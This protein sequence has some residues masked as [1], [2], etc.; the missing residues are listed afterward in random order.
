MR[1]GTH[2]HATIGRMIVEDFRHEAVLDR[3]LR[4]ERRIESSLYR[5]L[6][7]MR[8]VFDQRKKAAEE[9]VKILERWREED[10]E[11]KKARAF[12]RC[13]APAV[14]PGPA[15]G[16]TNTPGAE[17]PQPS[18]IPSFQDS[19]AA[20]APGGPPENETCKTNPV[21]EEVSSV[22]CQVLSQA[23]RA[24]GPRS[25]PTSDFTLQTFGGTPPVVSETCKTNPISGRECQ[26]PGESCETNPIG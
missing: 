24:S 17:I 15:G 10:W 26:T 9:T 2:A 25:L 13:S 21:S 7:E 4:Y 18:T 14:S 22:K 1:L 6:K 8:G 19:V 12:A 3:L 20:P 16:T 5:T 11:A 23:D